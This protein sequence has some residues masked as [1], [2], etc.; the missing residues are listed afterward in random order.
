MGSKA[1]IQ[2]FK[3]I[4]NQRNF[5]GVLLNFDDSRI[6][7]DDVTIGVI[8]IGFSDIKKLM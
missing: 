4:N 1:R 7:I 3:P 6:K 5:L 8:G 2:I